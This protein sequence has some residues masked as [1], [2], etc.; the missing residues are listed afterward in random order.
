[1]TPP[2]AIVE[3]AS[4]QSERAI[5]A[6]QL[7]LQAADRRV[8]ATGKKHAEAQD[9]QRRARVDLGRALIDAKKTCKH[10]HWLPMLERHGIAETTARRCMELAGFVA[11]KSSTSPNV[12]DLP[13]LREAGIDKRPRK[14]DKADGDT[15]S[16]DDWQREVESRRKPPEP[17][18]LDVTHELWKLHDKICKFAESVPSASRQQVAQQLRETAKLI[19]EMP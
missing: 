7:A 4:G 18:T 8:E 19:E 13:T 2:S 15:E 5:H 16:S 11:A 1:M 12:E 10:G 14:S 3:P 9:E 17:P 6:A